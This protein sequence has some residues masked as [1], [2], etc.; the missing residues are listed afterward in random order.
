MP[1]GVPS[2]FARI[3]EIVAG[4]CRSAATKTLVVPSE[5]DRERNASTNENSLEKSFRAGP[6]FKI[7]FAKIKMATS[8]HVWEWHNNEVGVGYQARHVV[9]QKP[10]P[11]TSG[12]I[13]DMR[14]PVPKTLR[15]LAGSSDVV[16]SEAKGKEKQTKRKLEAAPVDK[17]CRDSS[18]HS[19][20]PLVSDG[21]DDTRR[22]KKRRHNDPG[23]EK[24]KHHKKSKEHK[25]KKKSKKKEKKGD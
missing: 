5:R 19:S 3:F 24:K 12:Q 21:S 9:R 7:R 11:S 2:I 23:D 15:T 16:H 1:A 17:K 14:G 18:G 20:L 8:G 25:S 13:I 22:P 10:L 4:L 6:Y